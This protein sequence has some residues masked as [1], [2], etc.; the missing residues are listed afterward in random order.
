MSIVTTV[1]SDKKSI[2]INISGRFDYKNTKDFRHAYDT[3][4]AGDGATYFINLNHSSY[5]D[6]SA[7][8]VLL[9]LREKACKLGGNVILDRP[10][11]SACSIL[12][13]ANFDT[14]FTINY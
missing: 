8:G 3:T 10:S 7:L 14:L 5:L 9:L 4:E 1:S 12:K 2:H 13:V 11:E 6:S